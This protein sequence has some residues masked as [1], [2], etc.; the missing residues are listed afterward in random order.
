[1]KFCPLVPEIC[2]GQV[3]VPKKERRIKRIIIRNG[4]KTISLP[5]LFGR[6]NYHTI[7]ATMVPSCICVSGINSQCGNI[8]WGFLCG[9]RMVV[10]FITTCAISTYRTYL[11][12]MD[13]Q[14][15]ILIKQ[16][17]KQGVEIHIILFTTLPCAVAKWQSRYHWNIVARDIKHHKPKPVAKCNIM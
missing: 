12:H 17:Y 16:L 3:H 10:G 4:A 8:C 5:N 14:I 6:L 11:L 15:F 7:K 13:V 1:M 2:H 9:D